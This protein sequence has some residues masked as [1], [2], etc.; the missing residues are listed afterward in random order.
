MQRFFVLV[1]LIA[2]ATLAAC[3]GGGSSLPN[4]NPK[5]LPTAT[6]TPAPL[7]SP[8]AQSNSASITPSASAATTATLPAT[9]GIAATVTVPQLSAGSGSI[10]VTVATGADA[11]M[12]RTHS[13]ARHAMAMAGGPYLLQL[14]FV[15]SQ[16]ISFTAVPSFSLDVTQYV[17]SAGLTIPQAAAL[18]QNEALYAGIVDGAGNF[19]IVGP[20]TIN[21]TGTAITVSYAGPQIVFTLQANQHYTIGVHLGPIAAAT[22][23]PAPTS[24]PSVSP[25]PTVAPTAS[26][27]AMPTA[28]PTATPT[29]TPTPGPVAATHLYVAGQ[30]ALYAFNLPLGSGQT[31]IPLVQ[32]GNSIRGLATDGRGTLAVETTSAIY[33]YRGVPTANNPAFATYDF[34]GGEQPGAL[35]NGAAFD[36][37]GNLYVTERATSGMGVLQFLAPLSATTPATILNVCTSCG[38]ISFDTASDTMYIGDI[39]AQPGC[40]AGQTVE[41]VD[42][43][44]YP[45]TSGS[46]PVQTIGCANDSSFS[47]VHY[48]SLADG[49]AGLWTLDN[50]GLHLPQTLITNTDLGCGGQGGTA[51][52][53]AVYAN[54][55]YVSNQINSPEVCSYSPATAYPSGGWGSVG[56]GVLPNH[57]FPSMLTVGP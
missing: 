12:A 46:Q 24:A 41:S 11:T 13:A 5:P 44:A 23:T 55:F 34:T 51:N 39:A 2:A 32:Y 8:A 18:L 56:G 45:Y 31:A 16:T 19:N 25:S 28:S 1:A 50:T 42:A 49:T 57:D 7:P 38:G 15:P 9:G 10:R 14:D 17:T 52:N 37:K 43:V 47:D 3:G 6:D 22:S 4:T 48:V 30:T 33:L 54:T 40:S 35:G 26:P 27:T 21:S 53:F 20:L 36:S 29:A